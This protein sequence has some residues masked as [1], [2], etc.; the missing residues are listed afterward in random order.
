[1]Y[2]LQSHKNNT[3]VLPFSC[4]IFDDILQEVV[5]AR[6]GL[7]KEMKPETICELANI[8]GC[9]SQI[10]SNPDAIQSFCKSWHCMDHSFSKLL[11]FFGDFE[12]LV[13]KNSIFSFSLNETCIRRLCKALSKSFPAYPPTRII[14]HSKLDLKKRMVFYEPYQQ[15]QLQMAFCIAL[16]T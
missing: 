12:Q 2:L 4:G 9:N 16:K 8:F 14:F 13:G 11:G 5:A 7:R 10:V 6:Y 1:M 3:Q 15:C